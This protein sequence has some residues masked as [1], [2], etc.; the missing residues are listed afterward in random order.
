MYYISAA[1]IIVVTIIVIVIIVTCAL[2]HGIC[3]RSVDPRKRKNKR[4]PSQSSYGMILPKD[5]DSNQGISVLQNIANESMSTGIL[6]CDKRSSDS[7]EKQQHTHHMAKGHMTFL[8]VLKSCD[9]VCKCGQ[10]RGELAVI[11]H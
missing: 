4:N 9:L 7:G 11:I 5:D 8:P 10:N 6:P 2:K 1:V 3:R